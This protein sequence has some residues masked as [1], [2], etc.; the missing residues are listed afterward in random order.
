MFSNR[1]GVWSIRKHLIIGLSLTIGLILALLFLVL[2]HQVDSEIYRQMDKT[3]DF[4]AQTIANHLFSADDVSLDERLPEYALDSHTEFFTLYDKQGHV[5]LT[6]PNC[7][8]TALTPPPHRSEANLHYNLVLP[9]GHH[10]RAIAMYQND[11]DTGD[12][13][14]LVVASERESWD[15]VERHLHFVIMAAILLATAA[16]VLFSHLILRRAFT[17]LIREGRRIAAMTP[18]KP[19]VSIGEGLPQELMPFAEAF[20]TG[21]QRLYTAV[22]RERSF[23]RDIAHELRT[24]LS[25]IRTSAESALRGTDIDHAHKG[26]TAAIAATER[27]QR[28]IDTL[29][30]LARY[31]SK[32]DQPAIDPLDLIPLLQATVQTVKQAAAAKNIV[33][34]VA[35]PDTAWTRSDIGILER[36]L[37]NLLQNAVEYAPEQTSMNCTLTRRGN[38]FWLHIDNQSTELTPE[39]IPRLGTRFWRKADQGGTA[40]H[41]GLGLALSFGLARALGLCLQF[42]LTDNRLQAELGPFQ[43]L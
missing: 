31:E 28:A 10:G 27:M 40:Q 8:D 26:L 11:L 36:I 3:L 42:R 14:L 37:S 1:S 39:D 32:Q 22:E 12:H 17:S 2:D 38:A 30:S 34:H 33:V 23:S 24:P 15:R 4:R 19:L 41:A 18:D 20:N 6:S 7:H 16:A 21:T 35:F 5:A 9:D 29:L 25:E 43:A 13:Y